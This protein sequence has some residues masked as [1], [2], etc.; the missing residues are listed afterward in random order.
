MDAMDAILSRCGF[1]C[2]LCLAYRP[3]I[4]AQP[5]NA[6]LL[7]DGWQKYFGF[8]VPPERIVCDGCRAEAGTLLDQACP[9]RP[10]VVSRQLDTCA[11]CGDYPC[12]RLGERLV[13][14]AELSARAGGTISPEDWERFIR[15]Y[16]NKRRLARLRSS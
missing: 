3:N 2:D 6:G 15:P 13:D 10:C 11:S 16:E 5:D 9:V 1:R 4:E 7:S 14:G 8:R 12:A